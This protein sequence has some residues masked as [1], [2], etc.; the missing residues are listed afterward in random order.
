MNTPSLEKLHPPVVNSDRFLITR[1]NRQDRG[2]VYD[3]ACPSYI[4]RTNALWDLM[5]KR[6]K[7]YKT[8]LYFENSY[9]IEFMLHTDLYHSVH[10]LGSVPGT[11]MQW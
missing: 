6:N 2:V 9:D 1:T 7:L 4:C 10:D 11:Y 8:F 5:E 3:T